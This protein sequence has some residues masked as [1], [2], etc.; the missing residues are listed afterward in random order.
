MHRQDDTRTL[1][2]SGE[3]TRPSRHAWGLARGSKVGRYVVLYEVGHGG[4]G[5]VYAAYDPE[6]DRKVAIKRLRPDLDNATLRH[7]AQAMAQLDHPNVAKVFDVGEDAEGPF[8]AMEFIDGSNLRDWGRQRRP[9]TEVLKVYLQAGKGLAATH[10]AGLVHL[11]FKPSNVLVGRDGRARVV[12]FGIAQLA[13]AAVRPPA[14]PAVGTPAYLAPE[15]VAGGPPDARSDQYSFCAALYQT[16]VGKPSTAAGVPEPGD[17]PVDA[18]RHFPRWLRRTLRRGL[19]AAPAARFSSMEELLRNLSLD[20]RRRRR[21]KLVAAVLLLLAGAWVF[22]PRAQLCGGAEEQLAGIWDPV[23]RE[24]VRN[25]LHA[26]EIPGVETL[27]AT[28]EDRLGRF[29]EKWTAMHTDACRATY[30]RGEQSERLLDR[31]MLCLGSH[32]SQLQAVTRALAEADRE[33]VLKVPSL[34]SQLEPLAAC[35]DRARLDRLH[36]PE[37]SAAALSEVMAAQGRIEEQRARAFTGRPV[38]EAVLDQALEVATGHGYPPLEMEALWIQASLR[39]DEGAFRESVEL[40]QRAALA[41]LAA[42]DPA[43]QTL[44]FAKMG[45]LYGAELG[46][47]DASRQWLDFAAAAFAAVSEPRPDI[48]TDLLI[49]RSRVGVA[50]GQGLTA[51][52]ADLRRA[53]ELGEALYGPD[54]LRLNL[55]Y[56]NLA[57]ALDCELG[58]TEEALV[59]AQRAVSIQERALGPDNPTLH[60]KVLNL[61]SL[62]AYR[63]SYSAALRIAERSLNI[64]RAGFPEGHFAAGLSQ[65]LLGQILLAIDRPQSAAP[66]LEQAPKNLEASFSPDHQLVRTARLAQAQLR[67]LEADLRGALAILDADEAGAVPSSELE[68]AAGL[69]R[70]QIQVQLGEHRQA[71]ALLESVGRDA[72][73]AALPIQSWIQLHNALA[74][75][76]L[77]LG[78]H[79]AAR[80]H[81]RRAEKLDH[82][83]DPHCRGETLW[84]LARLRQAEGDG[85]FLEVARQAAQDLRGGSARTRRLHRE[86][87]EWRRHDEPG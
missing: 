18:A 71:L 79:E 86:V 83:A 28:V 75:A 4:M 33:I 8:I 48:E 50:T 20:R 6:L 40:L 62:H 60:L 24:A 56:T 5:T 84:I 16:L 30:V 17:P 85:A 78:Q 9:W 39:E 68:L 53:A 19:A 46:D 73:V 11:D 87:L 25:A 70:G 65:L 35:E 82:G 57:L 76:N 55:I 77:Q 12:D 37:L 34:L 41:A 2:G 61:A 29:A 66:F 27:L 31:R 22:R 1:A 38:D 44:L 81:L 42:G 21:Q 47:S 74:E 45:E 10:A 49:S 69:L 80:S 43:E 23:A 51:A 32:L 14:L 36:L 26:T 72:P 64:A 63:G 52:L 67:F 13:A 54:D 3:I 59:W 15:R 7:E 58:P